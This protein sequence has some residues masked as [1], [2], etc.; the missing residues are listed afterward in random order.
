[1][2]SVVQTNLSDEATVLIEAEVLE[3]PKMQRKCC[4]LAKTTL[5]RNKKSICI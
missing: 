4:P 1:M 5:K 3:L 2:D